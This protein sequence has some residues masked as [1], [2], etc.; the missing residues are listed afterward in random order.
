MCVSP[1]RKRQGT[2]FLKGKIGTMQFPRLPTLRT[3]EP[4]EELLVKSLSRAKMKYPTV[5]FTDPCLV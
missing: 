3:I 2:R 4:H 5:G 1:S